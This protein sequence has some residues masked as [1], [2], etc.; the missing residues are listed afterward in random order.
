M[1]IDIDYY[2]KCVY[3]HIKYIIKILIQE[4]VSV[5]VAILGKMDFRGEENQG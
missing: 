3:I 4:T 2:N 1:L 5:E